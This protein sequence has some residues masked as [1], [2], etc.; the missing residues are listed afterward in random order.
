MYAVTF[1]GRKYHSLCDACRNLKISYQK[2][3]RL[4]RHYEKASHNPAVAL[5][6][7]C[8]FEHLDPTRETKTEFY[9]LDRYACKIR[10]RRYEK[11]CREV[12]LVTF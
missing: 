2:V 11:R 12:I 8:G 7:A 4:M 10:K 1:A 5:A 3:K 9:E 6:W